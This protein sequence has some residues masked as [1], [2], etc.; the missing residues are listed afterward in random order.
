MVEPQEVAD[1]DALFH[2]A[3]ARDWRQRIAIATNF[4]AVAG[5]LD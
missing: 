5:N 4:V 2:T 3:R 1:T